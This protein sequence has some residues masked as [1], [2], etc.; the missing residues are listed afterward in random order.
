MKELLK[1]LSDFQDEVVF[2]KAKRQAN[3]GKYAQLKDIVTET[4]P[5]LKKH[6]LQ[7]LQYLSNIDTTPAIYTSLIH[8]SDEDA[9]STITPLIHKPEDPQKWGASI[10]YARRYAYV[11]ILGLLVDEDDDGQLA[12]TKAETQPYVDNVEEEIAG[13]HTVQELS[14]LFN[15]MPP[16]QR[17][18]TTK[19]FTARKLEINNGTA[20]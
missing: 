6:G 2:V 20:K 8:L 12:S 4:R 10:T 16:S 3:Y 13:C 17:V 19:A 1:A 11:T 5:A 15:R 14:K 18:E 7:V 9:I